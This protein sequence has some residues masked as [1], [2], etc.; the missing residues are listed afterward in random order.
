MEKFMSQ[1]KFQRAQQKTNKTNQPTAAPQPDPNHQPSIQALVWYK[2]E[3]WDT[4]RE[5][6]VD[7]HLL[8][9]QYEDWLQRAEAMKSQVEGTGDTVVKVHIDPETFPQ[10]CKEKNLP[11][12]S[13]ARSQMAIEV[14][15]AQSFSI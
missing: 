14:I 3:H 8:P 4:L 2:K 7:S 15:Q 12:N 5:L 9:V 11:L 1:R 6:F 10:W 13:E